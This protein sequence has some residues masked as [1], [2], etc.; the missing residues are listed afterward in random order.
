M[1]RSELLEAQRYRLELVLIG[2]AMT[3]S[4][5][6]DRILKEMAEDDMG[7]TRTKNCLESI[8]DSNADGVRDVFHSMAIEIVE[9]KTILESLMEKIKEMGRERRIREHIAGVL[10]ANK[11][12]ACDDIEDRLE[13]A[14]EYVRKA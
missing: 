11:V 9:G 8:R 4:G 6:R 14:L 7:S 1:D 13:A 2:F 5:D 10:A 3:V 12:L